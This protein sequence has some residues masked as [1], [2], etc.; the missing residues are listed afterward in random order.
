MSPSML[1]KNARLCVELV[2]SDSSHFSRPYFKYICSIGICA[3]RR[4]ECRGASANS[5]LAALKPGVR[6]RYIHTRADTRVSRNHILPFRL[7]RLVLVALFG[8]FLCPPTRNRTKGSM[9]RCSALVFPSAPAECSLSAP[10]MPQALC[11]VGAA[12]ELFA[13]FGAECKYF[14]ERRVRT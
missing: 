6:K 5:S 9:P 1:H 14:S 11:T 7:M 4:P 12:T 10:T 8:P 3:P 13:R 2:R